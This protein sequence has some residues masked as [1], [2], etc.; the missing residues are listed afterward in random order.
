[1]RVEKEEQGNKRKNKKQVTR[2][3]L[4]VNLLDAAKSSAPFDKK[5]IS[6]KA[7]DLDDKLQ[8]NSWVVVLAQLVERLHLRQDTRGLN[9]NMSKSLSSS[10]IDILIKRRK[11]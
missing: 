11:N 2:K 6:L 4:F 3:Q 8:S 7:S 1:M 10:S 5:S 9:A